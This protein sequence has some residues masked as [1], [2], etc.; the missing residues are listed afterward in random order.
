MTLSTVLSSQEPVLSS[1]THS[2]DQLV[3]S[4]LPMFEALL[5]R[6]GNSR[7]KQTKSLLSG[8]FHSNGE[9][10]SK[11]DKEMDTPHQTVKNARG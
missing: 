2:S 9:T 4:K 5:W 1:S 10:D 7:T 11:T 8:G 3:L 6:E